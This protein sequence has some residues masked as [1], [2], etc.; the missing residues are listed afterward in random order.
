M[1]G[2]MKK[3]K[4]PEEYSLTSVDDVLRLFSLQQIPIDNVDGS[5]IL[6]VKEGLLKK[7]ANIYRVYVWIAGKSLFFGLYS[8]SGLTAFARMDR[9]KDTALLSCID[10]KYQRLCDEVFKLLSKGI[11]H[12]TE[13]GLRTVE[14]ESVNRFRL[15]DTY[16]KLLDGFAEITVASAAIKYPAVE[17]RVLESIAT[18]FSSVQDII[19][20]ICR[21]Y[22]SGT[23]IA[24]VLA[25]EW[26]FALAINIDMKEYTPSYINWATNI[27]VVGYEAIKKL[28]QHLYEANVKFH[29]YRMTQ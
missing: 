21:R 19:D 17:R 10:K 20:Y 2:S 1:S 12:A 14:M 7:V 5:I 26:M 16:E 24:V 13:K 15:T 22:S 6:S 25:Q 3:I 28:E 23:Y 4:I 27:R 18:E 29:I 11:E 8:E 9:E